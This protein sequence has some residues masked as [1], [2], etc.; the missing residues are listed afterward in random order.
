MGRVWDHM[1]PILTLLGGFS[2]F[3]WAFSVCMGTGIGY[4]RPIIGFFDDG[5]WSLWR[6]LK[7]FFLGSMAAAT[8]KVGIDAL[9]NQENT[10]GPQW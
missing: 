3:L 10:K 7:T 1:C 8:F 4:D 2:L 9:D 6:L 5:I